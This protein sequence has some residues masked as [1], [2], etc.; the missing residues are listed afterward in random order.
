MAKSPRKNLKDKEKPTHPMV[1]NTRRTLTQTQ[2]CECFNI[3]DCKPMVEAMDLTISKLGLTGRKWNDFNVETKEDLIHALEHDTFKDCM[4]DK[5]E[6]RR[7]HI[8]CDEI[9][10]RLHHIRK[11]T[12]TLVINQKLEPGIRPRDWASGSNGI[13][14][15]ETINLHEK[16]STPSSTKS[17]A[18]SKVSTEGSD[19]DALFAKEVDELTADNFG[20]QEYDEK[21]PIEDVIIRCYLE[22]S[23]LGTE[24]LCEDYQ[25]KNTESGDEDFF[26][27]SY[28]KIIAH[29]EREN[30]FRR[31]QDELYTCKDD[32]E[33]LVNSSRYIK[34]LV[35]LSARHGIDNLTVWIRVTQHDNRHM[36]VGDASVRKKRKTG[37]DN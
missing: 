16:S 35:K 2:V 22:N 24:I 17:K 20:H 34:T 7:R 30:L 18:A 31:G 36:H 3:D 33:F 9:K 10:K 12:P 27:D 14:P 25:R 37:T 11:Y 8:L 21:I 15:W 4:K 6:E 13:M 1:G 19:P 5:N 32:R 28:D 23:K 26:D 29:L